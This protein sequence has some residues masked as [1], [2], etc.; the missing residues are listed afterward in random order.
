MIFL[1]FNIKDR[2]NIAESILNHV[3]SFGFDIWYDR[4]EI[5]LGDNRMISN[6]ENGAANTNIKY[7]IVVISP[8]FSK[9]NYCMKEFDILWKRKLNNEIHLFP[10]FYNFTLETIPEKYKFLLDYVCKFIM[11]KDEI[12]FSIYHIVSKIL[13]DYIENLE[14][15]SLKSISKLI[16]DNFFKDC[17]ETYYSI[18]RNNYNAK[19][20][21]LYLMYK[22][23]QS[24]I[25]F[26]DI[27]TYLYYGFDKLYSFSKL[28]LQ[29]DLR[30]LQILEN[31]IIIL[32]NRYFIK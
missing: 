11:P 2:I 30:E 17:I 15:N 12:I 19:M 10:I 28:N 31:M 7:A 32:L 29:T 5:F 23:M 16:D 25:E 14:N 4:K 27:P 20:T 3:L 9:G 21:T 24:K 26:S 13:Y 18:D 22:Y 1:C 6:L 8:E